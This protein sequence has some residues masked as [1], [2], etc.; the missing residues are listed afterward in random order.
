MIVN[1]VQHECILILICPSPAIMNYAIWHYRGGDARFKECFEK[2]LEKESVYMVL[3]SFA[4]VAR[5]GIRYFRHGDSR[6]TQSKWYD[7]LTPLT[8]AATHIIDSSYTPELFY[9]GDLDVG[10][11]WLAIQMQHDVDW[12]YVD[13]VMDDPFLSCDWHTGHIIGLPIRDCHKVTLS[14]SNDVKWC[15][16]VF[17]AVDG[18][19]S[20]PELCTAESGRF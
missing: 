19:L 4:Y 9:G 14:G 11:V 15:V 1:A 5:Y 17:P 10:L 18:R 13:S 20:R 2:V 12:T 7:V 6:N 8:H 16:R 3:A